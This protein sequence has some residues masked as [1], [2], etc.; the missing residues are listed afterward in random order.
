[1]EYS[2]W[3][4]IFVGYTRVRYY[5][6]HD[7]FQKKFQ[8]LSST[9]SLALIGSGIIGNIINR[10]VHGYVI[11]FIR[12]IRNF[13]NGKCVILPTVQFFAMLRFYYLLF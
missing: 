13:T 12:T 4:F 8:K 1:M 11:D 3:S 5:R 10:I 7:I 2:K 9:T 6:V